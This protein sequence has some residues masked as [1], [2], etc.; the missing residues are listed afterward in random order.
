MHQHSPN[1]AP[2]KHS[3]DAI[4]KYPEI[5]TAIA[6]RLL[7]DSQ[8]DL[9]CPYGLEDILTFKVSPTPHFAADQDRMKVYRERLGKKKWQEKWE[10][11]EFFHVK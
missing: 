6:A 10:K 4:S 11:L 8:V 5:C 1:T 7:P 9:F 3:R 2:Y